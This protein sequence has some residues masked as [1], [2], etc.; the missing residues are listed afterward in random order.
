[1]NAAQHADMVQAV[2]YAEHSR[3]DLKALQ[4]SDATVD[5]R[6]LVWL[7][8]D[9][10]EG[11]WL[12]PAEFRTHVA[13][14]VK[15]ANSLPPDAN[16]HGEND[17]G[18]TAALHHLG[19]WDYQ[20]AIHGQPGIAFV[21]YPAGTSEPLAEVLVRDG[22]EQIARR[23]AAT[24]ELLALARRVGRLNRGAG[25]IGMGMLA[26]LVEEARAVVVKATGSY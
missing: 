4:V 22:A 9:G 8:A 13:A 15:F 24:H 26:Q 5:S 3:L 16:A 14:L 2:P 17:E 12:T 10:M 20:P 18:R 7:G 1:M 23:M 21:V 6:R 19:K 11:R 25:E